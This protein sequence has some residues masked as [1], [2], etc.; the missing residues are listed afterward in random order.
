MKKD[1]F[2]TGEFAAICKVSKQ[3]LFY[4]DKEGIFS[5]DFIGENGYRYYSYTQIETFTVLTV[6][7]GL[8]VHIRDIK[9][10]MDNRSPGALIDLLESK[11]AEIN[12]KI[13][14]LQ[15][16]ARY[17]DSRI[18]VTR[19][20]MEAQPGVICIQEFPERHLITSEYHGP[21]DTAAVTEAIGDH[22]AHCEK[23]GLYNACSIGCMIPVASVSENGYSYSR[24]YTSV[25]EDRIP[26]QTITAPGGPHLVIYDDHGY[27][28]VG[29]NC[30]RLLRHASENGLSVCETIYEDVI[31]D[32]LSTTGYF[33]YLVKLSVRIQQNPE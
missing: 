31:L 5:P 4:Y 8:G 28:N 27:E 1:H 11:K 32:D 29:E 15:W 10:H 26:G 33:N 9:A 7:R 20:G 30:L 21:D 22:L 13:M 18:R 6:L 17:I 25:D 24:F 19:E 23:I 2:T 16:S 12:K 14:M 3:T